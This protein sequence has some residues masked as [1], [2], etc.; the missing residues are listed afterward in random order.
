M[1]EL[2][3]PVAQNLV[4]FL[5]TIGHPYQQ[6]AVNAT[7]LNLMKWCKGNI[8]LRLDP[9]QQAQALVEEAAETWEK[10]P[11]GGTRALLE[12]F[13]AKYAP[14]KRE[15]TF[16][17]RLPEM[18]ARG[19]LAAPCQH[20]EPGAPFCPYGG[21]RSHEKAAREEREAAERRAKVIVDVTVA[22]KPKPSIDL[23]QLRARSQAV[24][25]DGERRKQEQLERVGCD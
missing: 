21:P 22:P 11:E 2:T 15:H 4:G 3:L 25:E 10:W 24:Y 23:E 17:E 16:E 7:A 13:R 20:C 14:P 18:I 19:L 8:V 1:A 12:L 9:E 6:A 5:L